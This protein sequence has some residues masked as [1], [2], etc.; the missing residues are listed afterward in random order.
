[1]KNSL[2]ILIAIAALGAVSSLGAKPPMVGGDKDAHGCIGSAGYNYS[3]VRKV[4]VRLFE[5][6]IRLDPVK[7]SGSAVIS[8]FA[9]FANSD[10]E[11]AAE[12]FLPHAKGSILL[13]QV[14]SNGAGLW[15]NG[16]YKLE[17][18]KGMMTLS[19]R[20]GATLYQGPVA[21]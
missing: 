2:K 6:G 17:Q 15:R 10:N 3:H 16:Q 13:P 18:W 5:T 4:C 11:G 1:M 19:T 21:P 7:K 14:K 9:V 8:A 12:I 20:K